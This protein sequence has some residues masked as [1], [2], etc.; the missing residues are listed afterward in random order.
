MT[1]E[2]IFSKL[3]THM[4]EGIMYH[5]DFA[6]VFNFLCLRGYAAQQE[7]QFIEESNSYKYLLRYYTKHYHNEIVPISASETIRNVPSSINNMTK[8]EINK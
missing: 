5:D 6:Q 1:V 8:T 3:G 7:H 4:R 2:E